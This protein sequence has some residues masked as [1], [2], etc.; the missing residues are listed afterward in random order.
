MGYLIYQGTTCE[1]TN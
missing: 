1:Q